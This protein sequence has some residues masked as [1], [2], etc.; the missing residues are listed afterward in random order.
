[1]SDPYRH[2][3]LSPSTDQ[4]ESMIRSAGHYVRPSEDLRPRTLDAARQYCNDRRAEQKLG[5]FVI[6]VLLLLTLSSPAS[7]YVD[8]LRAQAS[9]PT[10]TEIQ[11]RALEYGA[12]HEIGT[13]WGL[14]EAFTQLRR[15]QATRLGQSFRSI[16]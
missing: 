6:A 16:K 2:D 14:T 10:A 1:L 5:G 11:N 8:V 9:A 3:D 13:N 4:I 15:V 12:R 7:Q